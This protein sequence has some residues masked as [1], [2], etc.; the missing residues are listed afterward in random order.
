MPENAN[1]W[2]DLY[3]AEAKR[4]ARANFTVGWLMACLREHIDADEAAEEQKK[5]ETKAAEIFG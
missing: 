4:S 5:A 1:F 2:R 3:E